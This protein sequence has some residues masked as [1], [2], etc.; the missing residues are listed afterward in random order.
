MVYDVRDLLFP[1]PDYSGPTFN[2]TQTGGAG[3]AGGGGSG[4]GGSLGGTLTTQQGQ[5]GGQG[6]PAAPS[7][8]VSGQDL[9]DLI[10]QIIG[11]QA[12]S[13]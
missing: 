10:T 11:P 2:L 13:Y 4:G 6:Q 8:Q 5:T 9:V 12:G 7:T 3:G 1:V